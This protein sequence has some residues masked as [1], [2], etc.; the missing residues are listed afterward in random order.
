MNFVFNF[1]YG[2]NGKYY[3]SVKNVLKIIAAPIIKYR[4][5]NYF[6]EGHLQMESKFRKNSISF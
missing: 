1:H 2:K 5:F 4:A 6:L 3:S